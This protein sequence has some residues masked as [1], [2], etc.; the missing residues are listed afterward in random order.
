MDLCISY[1]C[2]SADNYLKRRKR[3]PYKVKCQKG[4]AKS[5]AVPAQVLSHSTNYP[6]T[7]S[8]VKQILC[9]RAGHSRRLPFHL[10]TH[11][12]LWVVFFWL[13]FKLCTSY[14]SVC[15]FTHY[16]FHC[17]FTHWDKN[18]LSWDRQ[19]RCAL[20]WLETKLIHLLM[21]ATHCTIINERYIYPYILAF[22]KQ[23]EKH[24][25]P[26]RRT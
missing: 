22:E 4:T 2:N 9:P 26:K 10:L 13:L 25:T 21:L 20:L 15:T 24:V 5:P 11:L 23:G 19:Q 6:S 8:G 17:S 16:S 3:F 12:T 18:W 14:F 7:A 1:L